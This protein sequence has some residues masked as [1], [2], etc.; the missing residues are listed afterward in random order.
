MSGKYILAIDQSTQG[1]K[2]LLFD[3]E[4]KI[5]AKSDIP[6]EQI[7][8]DLGWVEHNPA[9]IYEN[10]IYIVKELIEK[11][12]IHK[13]DIVGLGITNQRETVVAWDKETGLPVYNAIVWQ[14]TRG[15]DIC[16]RIKEYG[17]LIQNRTGLPL[18]PYFS[19]AK[20]AWILE[21]MAEAKAKSEKGQLACGTM[22]S[23][24]IYKL[25][26]G[27]SFKT[28]YSNASRTQLYNIRELQWDHDICDLFGI[29]TE[30]LA[31][32]CNSNACFGETDFEG[33]LDQPI[34]IHSVF[35]DSHAALFGQNCLS[36]GKIKATYG[37]GS[38]VMMNIG[39]TPVFSQKGIAT[40]LA[41]GMDGNVQYVLEGNIN[42]SGAVINW[43][44]N[45]LRLIDAAA[46]TENFAYKANP[47][48]I[49]YLVPA[50]TGL[51][52]PYWK[53]EAT[54]I[55][56]G[57]T[58]L[59]GKAEIIR[60]ALDSIAYQITS[61][62]DV[63]RYESGIGIEE[64]R[65]DGGPTDNMYLMQFQSDLLDIPV[66]VPPAKELSGI[67]AAYAAG[68]AMGF[69]DKHKV[70]GTI[71][72]KTFCANMNE[73]ERLKKMNGWKNA[74]ELLNP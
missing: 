20:I 40:S 11:A 43:L 56:C 24:L 16:K 44:K 35:G 52:A 12:S 23:W 57:M 65:V 9:Q 17:E 34:P 47:A 18:S 55:L 41:W 54:A 49:T 72:Y 13:S 69:F 70:L 19:A 64:L 31:E 36:Q 29:S 48:D 10:V 62:I 5:V 51:G 67:G 38:S 63:M 26:G 42:Y 6:H 60:A 3:A 33:F 25:T 74:V 15:N 58:R 8:N 22:D 14:C 2:A 71:K 21:N 59:T 73:M 37:T 50:F 28:D 4:G 61:I 30:S 45:D 66:Q 32:V 7:V 68:I 27:R 46:D 1:T 53:S 39:D